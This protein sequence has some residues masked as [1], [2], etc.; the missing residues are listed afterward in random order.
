MPVNYKEFIHP[1]DEA[2]RRQLETLPGFTTLT[3]WFF[4]LGL[5]K[6]IHGTYMAEKLR[7]ST[8]QLPEVYK[9]LP[10]ICEEFGIAEPELY[11]EMN[12]M[13]NAYTTGDKQTFIV[14][15]SGLLQTLKDD[16]ELSAVI[17]HECG[18]IACRHVFYSTM[19]RFIVLASSNILGKLLYPIT[20]A[21]NYWSRRSELSADRA[22][23]VY[24]KDIEVVS[25]VLIRLA[26]GPAELT[27]K[28]NI[29]EYAAQAK[30]YDELREQKWHRMLQA[31][32]I[33]D[34]THPFS[35]VRLNELLKWEKSMVYQTLRDKLC[36]EDGQPHCPRC[37]KVIKP[38]WNFCRGCGTK[39]DTTQNKE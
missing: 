22:E 26:G 34:R 24:V 36:A 17:A 6:F 31:G 7:L 25:N 33:M 4:D 3:K 30:Y 13:P 5:E 37:N 11:L 9:L 38:D 8:T 10:P 39:L 18:H 29:E 27:S 21:L 19:A 28:V 15:T 16:R 12:P 20:V 1:E 2:A 35:A 14:L 23:L 32:A